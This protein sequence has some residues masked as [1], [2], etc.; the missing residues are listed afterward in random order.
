MEG[1]A[2]PQCGWF[3]SLHCSCSGLCAQSR[4]THLHDCHC[5]LSPILGSHNVFTVLLIFPGSGSGG[6]PKFVSVPGSVG[7]FL[8]PAFSLKTLFFPLSCV[9]VTLLLSAVP[10]RPLHLSHRLLPVSRLVKICSCSS[11]RQDLFSKYS[12]GI[13]T[14]ILR[15]YCFISPQKRGSNTMCKLEE[16]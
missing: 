15:A 7:F 6:V 4:F 9:S 8:L 2:E 16:N 12:K 3:I 10:L 11:C 13:D 1:P 5:P 14:T